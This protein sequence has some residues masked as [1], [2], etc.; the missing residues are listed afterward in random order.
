MSGSQIPSIHDP[1]LAEI[2]KRIVFEFTPEKIYLFGSV[3]RSQ[4]DSDSDYDILVV[5]NRSD[6][7]YY[8]RAQRAQRALWGIWRAADVFVLTR[9]EFEKQK[10]VI[11]TL[12]EIVMRDGKELYAA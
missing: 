9:K 12:P 6:E 1:V 2:L 4:A 8:K 11:G 5:V 3:A 10:G 7:P